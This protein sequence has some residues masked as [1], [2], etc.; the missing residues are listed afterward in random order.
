MHK[1][2]KYA[3]DGDKEEILKSDSVKLFSLLDMIKNYIYKILSY[4]ITAE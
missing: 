1:I 4:S 3:H 2:I